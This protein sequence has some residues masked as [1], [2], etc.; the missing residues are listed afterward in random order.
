MMS[1]DDFITIDSEGPRYSGQKNINTTEEV[2]P[3]AIKNKNS[4]FIIT[5]YRIH[6][7]GGT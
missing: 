2:S 1:E 6:K 3:I 5:V 7:E 4:K